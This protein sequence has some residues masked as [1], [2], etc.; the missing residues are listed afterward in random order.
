MLYCSRALENYFE[1]YLFFFILRSYHI[2]ITL[3]CI[4]K[5]TR[6]LEM[7]FE[8]VLRRM[9]SQLPEFRQTN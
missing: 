5:H 9:R 3:F 2:E 1:V 8:N 7:C 6:I 4:P